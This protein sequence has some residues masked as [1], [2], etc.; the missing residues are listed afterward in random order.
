MLTDTQAQIIRAVVNVFESGSPRGDYGCVTCV[1]GDAGHLTYGRSQASLTSG[2]LY[3]LIRDYCGAPG[4]LCAKDLGAFLP[5]L[6]ARD[7]TLDHDETMRSALARAGADPAMFD[8]QDALFTKGFFEPARK[9]AE[10]NNIATALG[11]AVVYDSFIQGGWKIVRRVVLAKNGP[12]SGAV[13]EQRWI[14]DYVEARRGWLESA[15]GLL[16][17]SVYR[18]DAFRR[19]IDLGNW[20]MEL[21]FRVRGVLIDEAALDNSA[22]R[23]KLRLRTPPMNGEDVRHLQAALAARGFAVSQDGVF[24]AQ[25]ETALKKFQ[26]ARGLDADGVAGPQTWASVLKAE[27]AGL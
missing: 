5:R 26:A 18:M 10:N 13:S 7:I 15:G 12:V 14:A 20:D 23:R 22:P 3:L 1:E 27:A 11:T 21:P 2:S 6:Q 19:L 24:G 4:A 8:A 9:A 25:T 17:K 16:A